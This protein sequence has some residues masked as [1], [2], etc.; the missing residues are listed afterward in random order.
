MSYLDLQQALLTKL[1]NSAIFANGDIAYENKA[2]DPTGK[3][4]WCS[5]N[6][7][8]ATEEA[9]GKTATSSNQREGILQISVCV[10]RDSYNYANRQLELIDEIIT[11]FSYNSSETFNG[12]TVQIL[13][14]EVSSGRTVDSWYVRDVSINYLLFATR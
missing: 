8:P 2:F 7:I 4:E 1:I 13:E 10:E 9:A 5:I 14:T 11:E 12:Q 6:I 3:T